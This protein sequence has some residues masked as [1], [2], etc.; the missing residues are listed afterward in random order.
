MVPTS[1]SASVSS[2]TPSA[3]QSVFASEYSTPHFGHL[4]IA[5]C[6]SISL[7]E[8]NQPITPLANPVHLVKPVKNGR[9]FPARIIIILVRGLTWLHNCEHNQQREKHQRLDQRQ[10]KNH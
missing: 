5:C 7:W 2:A 9:G 10:T 4:F 8:K 1:E 6:A 3:G